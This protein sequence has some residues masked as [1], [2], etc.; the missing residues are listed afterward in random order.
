MLYFRKKKK[1]NFTLSAFDRSS[2]GYEPRI[3]QNEFDYINIKL[4][5]K[6]KKN[7]YENI[8]KYVT[9]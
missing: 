6:K 9:H 5:K 7:W 2:K 1:I 3:K 8:T 4:Y